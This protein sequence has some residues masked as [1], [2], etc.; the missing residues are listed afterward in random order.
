M[1]FIKFQ[2]EQFIIINQLETSIPENSYF[3]HLSEIY[4]KLIH[5]K[6]IIVKPIHFCYD[7]YIKK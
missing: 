2:L 3:T 1:T 5:E 6:E 7:M 4:M